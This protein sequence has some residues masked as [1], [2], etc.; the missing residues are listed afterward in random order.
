MQVTL[1]CNH[2]ARGVSDTFNYLSWLNVRKL[3]EYQILVFIYRIKIGKMPS[4]FDYLLVRCNSV[5][6]NNIRGNIMIYRKLLK[7]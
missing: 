3:V 5:H 2:H 4:Y 7:T 6:D 1:R